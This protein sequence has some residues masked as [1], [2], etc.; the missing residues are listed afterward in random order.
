MY[1]EDDLDDIDLFTDVLKSINKNISLLTYCDSQEALDF[2]LHTPVLPDYLFLDINMPGMN[3]RD[4]L[5]YIKVNQRLEDLP[6]I[7]YSTARSSAEVAGIY[8]DGALRYIQKANSMQD[9]ET[10]IVGVLYRKA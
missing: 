1:I 5:R 3:G 8:A 2:L 4:A 7:M 6:V 9:M 10:D